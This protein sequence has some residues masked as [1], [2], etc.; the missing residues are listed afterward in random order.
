MLAHVGWCRLRLGWGERLCVVCVPKQLTVYAASSA[1]GRNAP[2]HVYMTAPRGGHVTAATIE[3]YRGASSCDA[4]LRRAGR[5]PA[6]STS[7]RRQRERGRVDRRAHHLPLV[8]PGGLRGHY[9]QLVQAEL[10]KLGNTLGTGY[11]HPHAAG[12]AVGAAVQQRSGGTRRPAS[13]SAFG[14][15]SSL[16]SLAPLSSVPSTSGIYPGLSGG[17]IG[18]R[19]RNVTSNRFTTLPAGRQPRCPTRAAAEPERSAAYPATALPAGILT[20]SRWSPAIRASVLSLHDIGDLF[21]PISMEQVYARRVST[22]D[23][24]GCSSPGDPG[25]RALR[26]HAGGA[27][28]RLQRPGDLGTPGRRAGGDAISTRTRWRRPLRCRY[29]TARTPPRRTALPDALT[30]GV[31]RSCRYR[32]P[33]EVACHLAGTGVV[34]DGV[35]GAGRCLAEENP[36]DS[37][38]SLW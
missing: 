24:R 5:R 27:A 34:G 28:G 36:G 18:N 31:S 9:V 13:D 11:R 21:V 17:T 33:G 14:R 26:L 32:R 8:P 22:M 7:P 1:G 30:A 29:P 25:R 12:P 10:P 23:S 19:R 2:R 15:E 20:V 35:R 38:V 6:V 16:P 37:V 3:H 4:V